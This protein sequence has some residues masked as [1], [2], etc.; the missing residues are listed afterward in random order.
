MAAVLAVPGS[1]ASHD[2]AARLIHLDRDRSVGPLHVST[3]R[4]HA[5]PRGIRVHRPRRL[6]PADTTRRRGIPTTTPTRTLFDQAS[7]LRPRKLRDLFE[8]AEYLEELDRPRLRTLLDGARGRRG[9]GVLRALLGYKPLALSTIRSRLE[10]IVLTTCRTYDLPI[11]ENNAP[12]LGFEVDFVWWEARFV[13][14]ADGGQHKGERRERDNARDLALQRAGYLVRRY[15]EL[16]LADERAIA[17]E[18]R[19]I[20]AERLPAVTAARL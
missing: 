15:G 7:R 11:P 5:N 3:A 13:V 16:A 17:E 8:Q 18:I 9:L 12:L 6:D 4:G 14:E 2:M 10:R 20:L 19:E 1:V